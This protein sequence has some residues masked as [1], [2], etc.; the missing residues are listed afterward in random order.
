M[1][2]DIVGIRDWMAPEQLLG[3][4]LKMPCDIYA[5]GMTIYQVSSG[6]IVTNIEFEP[7]VRP[8]RPDVEILL[9][10]QMRFGN[11]RRHVG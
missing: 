6:V 9:I 11:S 7:K 10:C 5:F 8:E 2:G 4:S 3:K 1:K